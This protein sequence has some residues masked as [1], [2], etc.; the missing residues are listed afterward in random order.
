MGVA[1]LPHKRRRGAAKRYGKDGP[2]DPPGALIE[3]NE[4]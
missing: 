4:W 1:D 2:N 3:I